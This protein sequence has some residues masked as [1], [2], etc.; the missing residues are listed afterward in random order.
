ME[1]K[2]SITDIGVIII[3]RPK[4]KKKK[5]KKKGIEKFQRL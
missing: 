2:K 5:E 4:N 3:Q 1:S